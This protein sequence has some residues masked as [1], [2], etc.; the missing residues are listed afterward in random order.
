MVQRILRV[1][2]NTVFKL[3]PEQ[4]SQ[5]T[6][7]EVYSVPA[8]TT[9]EIHSYAYTD[10]NGAAFNG[11]IRVALSNTSL[12]GFNTW[13][14]YGLH[15]QVEFDGTVVYPQEDQATSPILRITRDTVFKRRPLQ[16]TQLPQDE[17]QQVARARSFNLQSYAYSDAQ[18][19][20]S[21]HIKFAL[22]DQ[23][24]FIRGLNTW[25]V[26]DQHAF[27]EFDGEV[28]YP[29]ED[30][31][32]PVLRVT[33][34]TV[35]KRRP[36]Q[37][38]S[39]AADE[40]YTVQQGTTLALQSYAYADASGSFNGH[41]KFAIKYE[42]DYVQYL[43]TWYVYQGHA[44]IEQAGKVVYPVPAAAPSPTPSPGASPS[45]SPSPA[46]SGRA[47]RLPGNRSTFYTDQPIIPG[48]NFTWGEATKNGTRI[49]ETTAIVNNIIALAR[50]LQR[51]RT[52]IGR[53]FRVNSWYRPPAVNRAVG[54]ASMSQHLY[55]RAA[56][57]EVS[58]YSGRR[59]ANA[60]MS[61]WPGGVGIYSNMP[62][63]VH[64]DVG[65]RRTWGF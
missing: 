9:Y 13:F 59:V 18:G 16:S 45:P 41:I 7:Q 64:L 54:G 55:G 3:R 8:G 46:F 1:T 27:V 60:V 20:F 35:F 4:S 36:V 28:I 21:S 34:T 15:A 58:G 38:S 33:Q 12:Q 65:S 23:A 26:Y 37:A 43:S 5:L 11:H 44:R 56:D 61:W 32:A 29:P 53:P 49:P 19:D 2:Q 40:L 25:Y 51:A 10:P 63:V 57:L 31:N 39:L 24:D 42:R 17:L 6:A 14:V 47:I 62:N 50:Q 52:Q 48:G 22:R 30:P